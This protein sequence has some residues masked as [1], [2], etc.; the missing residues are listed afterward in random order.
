MESL[1]KTIDTNPIEGNI[2]AKFDFFVP[3]AK[4]WSNK[5]KNEKLGKYCDNNK[6]IDNYCKA[7]MDALNGKYYVDDNQIVA[8]RARMFWTDSDR[9]RTECEFLKMQA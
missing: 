2:Y 8:M 1:V 5:K 6:D 4:S 3:M 9:G 7:I